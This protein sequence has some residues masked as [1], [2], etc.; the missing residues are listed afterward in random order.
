MVRTLK[1]RAYETDGQVIVKSVIN[2]P[3]E[4]GRRKVK[5]TGKKIPPHFIKEVIVSRNRR[6]VME[7]FWGKSIS[8]NPFL[9]FQIPGRKGDTITISWLDNRGNTDS[10]SAKVR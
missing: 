3:M 7:A 10:A 4:T 9:S 2:H 1:I 8:R 5:K 6:I